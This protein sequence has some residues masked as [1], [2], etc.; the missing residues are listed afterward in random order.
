MLLP[1][2]LDWQRIKRGHPLNSKGTRGDGKGPVPH[3]QYWPEPATRKS[4]TG[5]SAKITGANELTYNETYYVA[6]TPTQKDD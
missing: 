1:M 2:E 5:H 4:K 3:P 6:R